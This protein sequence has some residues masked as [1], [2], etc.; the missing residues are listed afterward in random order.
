MRRLT[1]DAEWDRAEFMMLFD[2]GNCSCHLSPPCGSCLHPGNP[3]NQDA[4]D[5]AWD[6]IYPGRVKQ[7]HRLQE[8]IT[9]T[10]RAYIGRPVCDET[11]TLIKLTVEHGLRS[12][13]GRSA[14]KRAKLESRGTYRRRDQWK[15]DR[16]RKNMQKAFNHLLAE[17]KPNTG[18]PE[19]MPCLAR[20]RTIEGQI[21]GSIEDGVWF[22]IEAKVVEVQP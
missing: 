7:I 13:W 5:C 2:G 19:G 21:Q 11:A 15:V 14:R 9:K 17:L 20:T 6:I 4:D 3:A 22:N 1:A 12:G 10:L 18:R 8:H 16:A